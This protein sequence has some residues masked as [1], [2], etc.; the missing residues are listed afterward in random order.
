MRQAAGFDRYCSA[1]THC[2]PISQ[3]RPRLFFQKSEQTP[4]T[5]FKPTGSKQLPGRERPPGVWPPCGIYHRKG[6]LFN[7]TDVDGPDH[8]GGDRNKPGRRRR[9]R[10]EIASL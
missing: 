6:A 10:W 1:P 8:V 3:G 4:N 5:G 2:D 9:E 7:A